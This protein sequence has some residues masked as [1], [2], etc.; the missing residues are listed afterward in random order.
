MNVITCWP[1]LVEPIRRAGHTPR[2]V[3]SP[4]ADCPYRQTSG[5][6]TTRDCTCSAIMRRALAPSSSTTQEI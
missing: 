3:D 1:S 4:P 2:L 5:G 6:C